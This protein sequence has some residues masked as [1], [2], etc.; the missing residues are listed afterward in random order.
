MLEHLYRRYGSRETL[1]AAIGSL[2]ALEALYLEYVIYANNLVLRR[3]YGAL[4][5][6]LVDDP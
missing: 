4:L 5:F 6:E 2:D 3:E 1:D